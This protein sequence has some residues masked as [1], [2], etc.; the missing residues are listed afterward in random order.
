MVK[1]LAGILFVLHFPSV[2]AQKFVETR[3]QQFFLHEKPLYYVGTNYWYGPTLG[4]EKNNKKGIDRLR[5][6][7]DFLKANGVTNLRVLAGAEGEGLV[8]GTDRVKPP[9]QKKKSV[10]DKKYLQGMDVL[11]TEMGKRNMKAVIF[12]SNNWEWSGGFLQYLEWNGMIPDSI[13]RNKMNWDETRDLVSKFYSCDDCKRNYLEQV[14]FVINRVNSVTGLKYIDDP[15]IMAWELANEPRPMRPSAIEQ[16]KQWIEA[17]ARFIKSKD[18]QHLV[19]I[20]TEGYIGTENKEVYEA[21]HAL[22]EIDYLTI[23]IWPKNWE[24][25]KG[26]NIAAGMDSVLDKTMNYIGVHA[27]IAQKLKK[28]LV[29]EEFGLPRDEHSFSKQST[30]ESRDK[31]YNNIIVLL[32]QSRK[33]QFCIGGV[34]FWSYGGN[35][36]PAHERWQA[37]DEYI[38]DPPMEE[39]GLNAVFDTDVSTWKVIHSFSQE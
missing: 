23:H 34:N 36:T 32:K 33:N 12:L 19:T 17:T 6:E 18:K 7:L 38:G 3:G 10:F 28:P 11:L 35:I 37:G 9:L 30:T 13:F 29:I 15:A 2:L 26:K 5:A 20:G 21:I 22:P 14:S 1:L 24:W 39:Q 27:A 8:A 31:Y 25:F 16:Y 4:L